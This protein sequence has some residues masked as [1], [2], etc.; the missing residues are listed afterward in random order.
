MGETSRERIVEPVEGSGGFE[1]GDDAADDEQ[2]GGGQESVLR[3]SGNRGGLRRLIGPGGFGNE[4]AGSF[5]RNAGFEEPARDLVIMQAGHVNDD[6]GFRGEADGGE[7]GRVRGA[8]ECGE[9]NVEGD[10]S[11]GEGNSRGSGG[12]K[13][14][15]DAGNNFEIDGGDAESADFLCG[16]A[17]E[18]RIATLEADNDVVLSGGR[19]EKRIDV[20]LREETETPAF[21][22]VDAGGGRRNETEDRFTDE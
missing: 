18:K 13:G 3:E 8:G 11:I 6:G 4:Q 7:D 15:G 5:G 2:G 21:A 1:G 16:A 17:E 14:G 10:A 19:D 22:N 12:S 20:V 9:E